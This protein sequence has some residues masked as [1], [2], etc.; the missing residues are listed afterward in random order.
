MRLYGST[1]D[2]STPK[3]FDEKERVSCVAVRVQRTIPK[4]EAHGVGLELRFWGN[5]FLS[6]S[7]L[8]DYEVMAVPQF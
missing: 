2:R 7:F 3:Q 8:G 5:C 4:Y 1:Q 6:A